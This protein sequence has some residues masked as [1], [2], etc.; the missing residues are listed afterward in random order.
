[1]P[2]LTANQ[3][4][5]YI[6]GVL[7]ASERAAVESELASC[8]ECRALLRDWAQTTLRSI[9]AREQ[10]TAPEQPLVHRRGDRLDA[11]ELVD[12]LGA[13][14]MGLVFTGRDLELDRDVAI[15]VVRPNLVASAAA[16]EDLLAEARAMAAVKHPNVVC[17]YA[18]GR[19]EG[20]AFIA[21]EKVDGAR[22]TEWLGE[23]RGQAAV[24]SV[25]CG[26]ARGLA[27]LHA[28]G[29]VHRD[30]KPDNILV[31]RDGTAKLADFGLARRGVGE[32][33]VG[34]PAFMAP[35]VRAGVGASPASDQYSFCLTLRQ[36]WPEAPPEIAAIVARGLEPEPERRWPDMG[37]LADA[38][39]VIA[40][41]GRPRRRWLAVA[42]V[43]TASTV[44]LAVGVFSALAPEPD[45]DRCSGLDDGPRALWGS[46]RRA[47]VRR[48]F[49]ASERPWAERAFDRLD[50]GLSAATEDLGA[51]RRRLCLDS[52]P[53]V[54]ARARRLCLDRV[55]T[56]LADTVAHLT[57]ADPQAV[58][59]AAELVESLADPQRC[60]GD[61]SMSA[62]ANPIA[63]AVGQAELLNAAGDYTGALERLAAIEAAVSALEADDEGQADLGLAVRYHLARASVAQR[64]Q[65]YDQAADALERAARPAAAAGHPG[66]LAEVHTQLAVVTGYH[67]SRVE[68]GHAHLE[69][70]AAWAELAGEPRVLAELE[71]ARGLVAAAQGDYEGA[72]QAFS[73][74]VAVRE[75]LDDPLGEAESLY[76]R[77]TYGRYLSDR[78]SSAADLERALEIRER[79][80][81]RAHPDVLRIYG[82]LGLLASANGAVEPSLEWFRRA[83]AEAEATLG[84]DDLELARHLHAL[85]SQQVI[86]GDYDA[87]ERNL[88][89][90]LAIR[91]RQLEAADVDIVRTLVG[92]ASLNYYRGAYAESQRYYALALE[93]GSEAYPATHPELGILARGYGLAALGAGDLD[94]ARRHIQR[95]VDIAREHAGSADLA[96]ALSDLGLVEAM[97]ER[98]QPARERVSESL[99][100]REAAQ[101]VAD[102]DWAYSYALLAEIELELGEVDSAELSIERAI[103]LRT[104]HG[105]APSLIAECEF[106]LA[107]IQ[108]RR[109]QRARARQTARAALTRLGSARPALAEVIREW[110]TS[111]NDHG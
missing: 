101:R 12:Y 35:E 63:A 72:A 50:R 105:V 13:G 103:A 48:Q 55:S 81:G 92:L 71:D 94:L 91:E 75:T 31:E 28:I 3:L 70:A 45:Q 17:V 56:D 9:D 52:P 86:H 39:E 19:A 2:C 66:R 54:R 64:R 37:A 21:M 16:A 97:A 98:W 22:L 47:A 61:D 95:A 25:F 11:Y 36:T 68:V 57:T 40:A 51:A 53:P 24:L 38:I 43:A 73:R 14:G 59:A 1:M 60:S 102:P 7:P 110:I 5:E 78:E 58:N 77:G 87:A 69:T 32:E 65:R 83:A 80:L 15:K 89:R 104:Q 46:Q 88:E 26:V 79:E 18:A 111:P 90:A 108:W 4:S 85:G 33:L 20:L 23:G 42:A 107:K 49:L 93:L 8:D 109:G 84:S 76:L 74:A 6:E 106:V 34:T 41:G 62:T 99:A 100:L 10:P 30:V 27:A 44:A 29:F 82:S 96:A 67:Q